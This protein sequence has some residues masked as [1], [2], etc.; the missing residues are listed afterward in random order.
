[1]TTLAVIDSDTPAFAAAISC[2]D[3]YYESS[4]GDK[5]RRKS[6][7]PKAIHGELIQV[8]E[9]TAPP[10]FAIARCEKFVQGIIDDAG[11]DDYVLF[12]GG[13]NNYRYDLPHPKGFPYKGNRSEMHTPFYLEECKNYLAECHPTVICDGYEA[14]DGCGILVSNGMEGY[15]E[16]LLCHIDKDMDMIEG[17]H[18]RWSRNIAG[19]SY[20][21]EFYTINH[22]EAMRHFYGQLLSGDTTDNIPGLY[23]LTGKKL[24]KGIREGLNDYKTSDGMWQY[25]KSV[26]S[27]CGMTDENILIQIARLLWIQR[28]EGEVWCPPVPTMN[29]FK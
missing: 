1:M 22:L 26:Y 11:C 19:K 4:A 24:T 12:I 29:A 18:M 7:A 13:G 27:K 17:N 25:V 23:K 10:K 21:A 15:D 6:D 16:L 28:K 14:D 20:P 9:A 3:Y 8:W 2:E 5:Y